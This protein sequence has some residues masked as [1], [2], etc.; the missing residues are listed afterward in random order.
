MPANI[1]HTEQQVIPHRVLDAE[2]PRGLASG[3]IT[4]VKACFHVRRQENLRIRAGVEA[5]PRKRRKW[6]RMASGGVTGE[7]IHDVE[8]AA[9]VHLVEVEKVFR[10]KRRVMALPVVE[11][12]V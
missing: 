6:V 4:T 5:W 7:R 3:N 2:I 12:I 11:R 9:R 1:S 8:N 10:T